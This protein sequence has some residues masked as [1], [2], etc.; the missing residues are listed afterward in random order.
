VTLTLSEGT[1]WEEKKA[2]QLSVNVPS[3]R[4]VSRVQVELTTVKICV[5]ESE[6]PS[7]QF[8]FAETNSNDPNPL[9]STILLSDNCECN[10]CPESKEG[11]EWSVSEKQWRESREF[12]L[13]LHFQ[14]E[15]STLCIQRVT[16]RFH[17]ESE[18]S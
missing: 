5:Y 1:A 9:M 11:L 15:N 6:T 2:K 18:F 17:F 13:D 16:I 12:T 7:V 14:G 4:I 10:V 8:V 3:G